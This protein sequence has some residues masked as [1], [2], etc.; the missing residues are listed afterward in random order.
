MKGTKQLQS[1]LLLITIF[2]LFSTGISC[3]SSPR[4]NAVNPQFSYA[5]PCEG[6]CWVVNDLKGNEKMINENGIQNWN[7][8]KSEF[9]VY[10]KVEKTGSLNIGILAKSLSGSSKLK[11]TFNNLSSEV[12]ISKST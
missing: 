3:Q 12:G 11:V 6:N 2:S 1:F 4:S 5:I 7:S 9:R 10:F 8:N